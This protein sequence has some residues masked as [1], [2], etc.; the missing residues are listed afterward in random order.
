MGGNMFVTDEIRQA[1]A[2]AEAFQVSSVY[3]DLMCLKVTNG[4]VKQDTFSKALAEINKFL[5]S[6]DSG[7]YLNFYQ[8]HSQSPLCSMPKGHPGAC[9]SSYAKYFADQFAN[10]IKDCDTTPGDDDILF[11]NR[12]RRYFPVL[13]TKSQYTVLNAKHRW[14]ANNVKLKAAIPAENAGTAFTVATAHFDFAAILMLQKGIETKGLP[15]EIEV[16]LRSRAA[17]V[18]AAFASMGV[19]ITD[20]NGNLCDAVLGITI[21]PEWYSVED[22]RDPNQIQ[23]GHVFPLTS[24]KFMTR[25]MNVIPITRRGNLIQSDNPLNEVHDFI[26]EAYEHTRPR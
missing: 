3:K 12:A 25:G 15:K 11:K 5:A 8:K 9:S 4:G 1:V 2:E 24:S 19:Y 26:K 21:E 13:V 7:F 17:E 22:H 16:A 20:K 14:K 18:V 6:D 23:F 10:K